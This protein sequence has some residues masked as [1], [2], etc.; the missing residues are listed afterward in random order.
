MQQTIWDG[1]S[2]LINCIVF[3]LF[4]VVNVLMILDLVTQM[5][6][7]FL[8]CP[9]YF[10]THTFYFGTSHTVELKNYTH[11]YRRSQIS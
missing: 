3:V 9:N 2:N 5:V 6:L 4:V 10:I 1:G 7:F 11:K 8:V